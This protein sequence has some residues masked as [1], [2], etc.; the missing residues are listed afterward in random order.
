MQSK[1][2]LLIALAVIVSLA[3][4]IFFYYRNLKNKEKVSYI[5]TFLRF[6]V[7]LSVFVLLINPKIEQQIITIKKPTLVVAV[8]N[9]SS[10]K[11]SG[12]T[13][14]ILQLLS[15][16]KGNDALNE[17][18]DIDYYS[19]GD[20][21]EILDS[22]NFNKSQTNIS[23]PFKQFKEVYK[24]TIAPT[25][26][27]TDG[28]QT[29]GRNYEYLKIT[30]SVYPIVVGDTTQYTDV[31]ITRLN[32]NKYAYLDNKFPVEIFLNYSGTKKVSSNF[33]IYKG[34]QK[35][36]A[37]RVNFSKENNSQNISFYLSADKV[38]VDYYSAQL[39]TAENEKNSLNNKKDFVVEVIDEQ[40][41]ILLLTSF[42]HP[43]VG[44]LKSAIEANK[45]RKVTIKVI[46]DDYNILKY[47]SVILYQPT[48]AFQD[49]FVELD[50]QKTNHFIITG[51]KT[52]WNFLNS[53]QDNFSKNVI[54]QTENYVAVYNQVFR[55]FVSND[56]G[57]ENFPPLT[58]QFGDV[59]F[60][61]PFDN[62]LT[63]KIGSITTEKSLLSTYEYG[64]KRGVVL[65][66][67]NSWRW[68]MVSKK[69][70]QSSIDYDNFIGTLMQYLTSSKKENR[71][72][73]EFE[74]IYYNNEAIKILANYLDKNY[75][76]DGDATLW[77]SVKNN[78]TKIV[79]QIPFSLAGNSYSVDLSGLD[80]GEYSFTVSVENENAT[81]RGIFK[82][83]D[84]DV[85]QQFLSANKKGLSAIANKSDGKLYY[86]DNTLNLSNDLIDDTRFL[87]IQKSEKK[88]NSLID[89]KWLL[90]L[91]IV[92]LSIEWFI[93]K[94]N[95][96]I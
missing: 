66:G 27:I 90:G 73:V 20:A 32:V 2:I 4:A 15:G 29:Y 45:Q 16:L 55:A 75:V 18:F 13:E 61:T 93:R 21:I 3:I 10:I 38:G 12:E 81:S 42:L 52:D 17:K 83:F 88:L 71:L 58:D 91:I 49:M 33:T 76:F 35:V 19:F 79:K 86:L 39:S 1:T 59:I 60:N 31:S 25:I 74:P 82:V 5:L 34:N 70:N 6:V 44:A 37:K 40:A 65:F 57:F 41:N 30:Q 72:S 63:Q 53:A 80:S 14:K 43:D 94:Y 48:S 77:L 24:N 46:G 84:F 67:E 28:N 69:D 54:Q 96:F 62:L 36:F 47:Q 26:L 23:K 51:T 56:I 9:S 92:S 68:R 64:E 78:E 8:D 7:L 95:G 87:S 89:W 85:E 11:N 50:H 22:L